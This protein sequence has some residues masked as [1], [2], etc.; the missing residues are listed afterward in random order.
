MSNR[1][2]EY[3]SKGLT[4]WGK[5]RFKSHNNLLLFLQE[6][7]VFDI[8]KIIYLGCYYLSFDANLE[9]IHILNFKN[10]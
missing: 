1:T 8:S 5:I 3:S 7:Y 9:N 2:K 6:H 4:D 10:E